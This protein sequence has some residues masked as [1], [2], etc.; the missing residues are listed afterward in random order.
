MFKKLQDPEGTAYTCCALG[1]L[2]RMLG[3]Y[4]NSGRYYREANRLMR[5]RQDIF[6]IAYSFCGLG[7]VERMA[8]RFQD[9]LPYYKKAERLYGKIGDRVSYAYTLWSIGT[10]YK[11]L[12]LYPKAHWAFDQADNLFR[13]T[14]DTRG[15]IYA[16]LGFAEVEWLKGRLAKGLAFWGKAKA[17]AGKSD[18]AWEKLHV[19]S[20]RGGKV[21]DFSKEYRKAGS[22]FHPT[23][24]PVNWP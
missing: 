4:G 5:Q 19:G 15:R 16:L 13:K 2:Y 9:S 17:I 11:M 20:L 18:Y 8:G 3:D 1:G 24:L 6:G 7:N 12:G 14:G 21:R 22:R 10:A 23:S